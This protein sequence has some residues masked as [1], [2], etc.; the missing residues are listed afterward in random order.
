MIDAYDADTVV[1]P[2]GAANPLMPASERPHVVEEPPPSRP[3][4]LVLS[5]ALE[6]AGDGQFQESS[7][8]ETETLPSTTENEFGTN[9]E[10]A[11]T[12]SQTHEPEPEVSP[13]DAATLKALQGSTAV[14]VGCGV[15]V[16]HYRALLRGAGI[17]VRLFTFWDLAMTS[18]RKRRAD[19]LIID[20]DAL[21][22]FTSKQMYTSAQVEKYMFGVLL[23][24]VASDD[25]RSALPEE[26]VLP[27]S[28]SDD[29]IRARL[30]DSLS[31]S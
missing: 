10:A 4:T 16:G 17:D 9:T 7:L 18:M 5:K 1:L 6:R 8:D 13:T 26:V 31:N 3:F 20:G 28:L 29:D 19:I 25:D 11:R 24:G 2:A 22:G 21:D 15:M 27:H 23:V 30:V 12:T 14:I